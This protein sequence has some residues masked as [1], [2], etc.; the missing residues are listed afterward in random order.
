[1]QRCRSSAAAFRAHK[2]LA[3]ESSAK[4]SVRATRRQHTTVLRSLRQRK[5]PVEVVQKE[6]TKE[7]SGNWAGKL[8][9]D[10]YCTLSLD[11]RV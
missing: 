10:D 3:Q 5:S 4:L 6:A 1:M 7:V 2:L 11:R 9:G 8:R